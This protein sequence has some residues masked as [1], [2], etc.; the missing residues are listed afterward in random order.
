MCKSSYQKVSWSAIHGF[1]MGVIR[2]EMTASERFLSWLNY[3]LAVIWNAI[4]ALERF[5]HIATEIA[6]VIETVF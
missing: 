4:T 3:V 1:K 5:L 6:I 2:D